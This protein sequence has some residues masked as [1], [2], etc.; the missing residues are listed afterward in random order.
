MKLALVMPTAHLKLL[1]TLRMGYQELDLQRVLMK[2]PWYTTIYQRMQHRGHYIIAN[3]GLAGSQMRPG[4]I[5][6]ALSIYEREIDEFVL[7]SVPRDINATLR[8]ATSDEAQLVARHTRVMAVPQGATIDEWFD[9]MYALVAM[10]S[11]AVVAVGIPAYYEDIGR[12]R[13]IERIKEDNLLHGKCVHLFG[14]HNHPQ[15]EIQQLERTGMVRGISTAVA[16]SY[17]QT[18]HAVWADKPV[19]RFD[20]GARP[21]RELVTNNI[22]ILLRWCNG[23]R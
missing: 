1:N 16:C 14:I 10:F 21:N 23:G 13:I 9:C 4:D 22:H 19:E 2:E 17:A 6:K 11:R 12:A 20:I 15:R 8:L 18:G 5:T 3:V 7:P